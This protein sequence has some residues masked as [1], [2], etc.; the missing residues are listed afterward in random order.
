MFSANENILLRQHKRRIVE[1]VESTLSKDILDAG[2]SVMAMQVSC[3]TP[4]CS[5][6]ETVVVV[7]FPRP[8]GA[9]EVDAAS[10]QGEGTFKTTILKPM[11]DVT[12]DDVLDALPPE[13][14][15]GG[16]KTVERQ[17]YFIR[18]MMLS[19]IE[20]FY[21]NDDKQ[22]KIL[23]ANYLRQSLQEYVDA[24]CVAPEFGQPFSPSKEQQQQQIVNENDSKNFTYY[25]PVEQHPEQQGVSSTEMTQSDWRM[26]QK[27]MAESSSSIIRQISDREHAAGVRR[28]GCPCCDS[29]NLSNIVD[30]LLSSNI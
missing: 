7:V 19:H 15:A 27:M 28:P 8:C 30:K 5:P 9:V 13:R 22:G 20:K 1:Y 26:K 21:P 18:D 16:R 14:F 29:D 3:K 2:T 24:G 6:L 25:R 11:V 10:A 4:G 12:K 17:C 23:M